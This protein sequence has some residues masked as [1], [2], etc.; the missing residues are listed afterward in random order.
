M[1]AMD[2]VDT[3]R[4]DR[5]LVERELNDEVRRKDLIDRL[6]E[7]YRGQGIDVPDRILEDGV[8]ALEEE[9][10][11]YKP[12]A[13]SLSTRLAKIYVSR[14]T[15]GR[16][17]GGAALAMVLLWGANYLFY[18]RPQQL[19]EAERVTELKQRLPDSLNKL[20]KDI[21]SEASDNTISERA[22]ALV[23]Q[24]L[25]AASS[26]NLPGARAAEAS[27]KD[28][29][30]A[31]RSVYEVR[32]VNR[33]GEVSGIWR[34]PRRNPNAFNYYLVVEAIGTDG[35]AIAQRITNEETGRSEKVRTWALRVDK[36]VFDRVAA[37]KA[38]DGIIQ[39]NIAGVKERGRIDPTWKIETS[40]GAITKWN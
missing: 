32:I 34:I 13:D 20:G 31:L 7:I 27:L 38:D 19:R 11:T 40:G 8:R 33:K 30:E 29:L 39:N 35:N 6:R 10:F 37:D 36:R 21:A 22:Q 12:P 26:G 28:M 1:I 2:V 18:T 17:V 14:G 23:R 9:R 25:N 16:Y 3:L 4:H 24:G 15:W 5:D